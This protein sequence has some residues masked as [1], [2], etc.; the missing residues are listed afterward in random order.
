[1]FFRV[2]CLFKLS[3]KPTSSAA[4]MNAAGFPN[5]YD[6]M[7]IGL[8]DVSNWYTLSAD[9]TDFCIVCTTLLFMRSFLMT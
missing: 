5:E 3:I 2:M 6:A 7:C 4:L 8:F 1:M 9:P